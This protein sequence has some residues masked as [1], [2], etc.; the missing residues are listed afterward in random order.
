[1]RRLGL[2]AALCLAG[3]VLFPRPASADLTAFWGVSPDPS[4]R[5]AKGVAIGL[6]LLVV[7]FEFEYSQVVED[8]LNGAPSLTTGM[9]NIVFM[10]PT[11]KLQL[12]ATTGGGLYREQFRDFTTTHFVSNAGGEIGRASCRERVCQ[13]V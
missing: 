7:G 9:G 8:E 1:M 3:V 4:S 10:T 11:V 12:Y 6:G 2:I 13:Y 5:S